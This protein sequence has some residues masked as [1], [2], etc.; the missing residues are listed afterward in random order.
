[1]TRSKRVLNSSEQGIIDRVQRYIANARNAA[2][3]YIVTESG[4][5]VTFPMEF[6]TGGLMKIAEMYRGEGGSRA[7]FD[8]EGNDS[9]KHR[10]TETVFGVL[11]ECACCIAG[12]AIPLERETGRFSVDLNVYDKMDRDNCYECD[13]NDTVTVKLS[14]AWSEKARCRHDRPVTSWMASANDI[15]RTAPEGKKI[16]LCKWVSDNSV[17]IMGWVDAAEVI[18]MWSRPLVK[19]IRKEVIYFYDYEDNYLNA[20]FAATA[21]KGAIRD[22][23]VPI[24]TGVL[25]AGGGES[26]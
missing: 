7:K 19:K 12:P 2:D 23:M 16:I 22:V 26:Q 13:L 10:V 9:G 6:I 18:S 15:V 5:L 17:L 25:P 4:I 20:G 8:R 21:T 1:M 3:S 24:N 14:G 11:A